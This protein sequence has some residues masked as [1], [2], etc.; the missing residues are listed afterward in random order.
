MNSE[1]KN[2]RFSLVTLGRYLSPLPGQKTTGDRKLRTLPG[3]GTGKKRVGVGNEDSMASTMFSP[4]GGHGR[5][6]GKRGKGTAN[7]TGVRA[8]I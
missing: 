6:L 4:Q 8:N 1:Y 7:Q 3:G 2:R 5:V